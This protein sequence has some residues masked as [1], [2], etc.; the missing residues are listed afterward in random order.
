VPEP[1]AIRFPPPSLRK[2]GP[3]P[4]GTPESA[5][6]KWSRLQVVVP[7]WR[8]AGRHE[9]LPKGPYSVPLAVYRAG[10]DRGSREAWEFFVHPYR[11]FPRESVIY[12]APSTPGVLGARLARRLP[13]G[14]VLYDEVGAGF[15]DAERVAD[16]Y[17]AALGA[18]R[19]RWRQ[20]EATTPVAR[21][22]LSVELDLLELLRLATLMLRTRSTEQVSHDIVRL[23]RRPTIETFAAAAFSEDDMHALRRIASG[24]TPAQQK[25]DVARFRV[26]EEDFSKLADVRDVRRRQVV[27]RLVAEWQAFQ[28]E[29]GEQLAALDARTRVAEAALESIRA[30]VRELKVNPRRKSGPMSFLRRGPGAELERLKVEA[31]EQLTE[32]AT[33]EAAFQELPGYANLRGVGDRATSFQETVKRVYR[34]ALNLFDHNVTQAQLRGLRRELEGGMCS[35]D[36]SDVERSWREYD[37]RLRADVLPRLLRT[38]SLS[39][40]LLRRPAELHGAPTRRSVN[41]I[42]RLAHAL[43]DYFRPVRFGSKT[44]GEQFDETWGQVLQLEARL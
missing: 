44:V 8:N 32:L 43:I 38:Y 31:R 12:N 28:E 17:P 22:L 13:E 21:D 24:E 9:F 16:S 42:H 27:A 37:V 6:E 25:F 36:P 4:P 18:L 19:E 35:E 5:D 20:D 11:A 2:R 3:Q 26:H 7:E 14:W 15:K 23:L 39:A 40:Y 33:V 34:V 1:D 29:H 10:A 41:R 30:R